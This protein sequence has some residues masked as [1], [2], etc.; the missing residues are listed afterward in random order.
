[1]IALRDL[2][3]AGARKVDSQR[4]RGVHGLSHFVDIYEVT[5]RIGIYT[6]A[7]VYAVADVD[8]GET[9]LGRDVLN[10]FIVTLN[11]LA[12]AVEVSQ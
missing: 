4:M 11:G 2:K 3:Q 12:S 7:K 9:I 5:V 8:N 1:M 6:V 10:H